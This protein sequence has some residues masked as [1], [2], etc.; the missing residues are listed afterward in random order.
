[1]SKHEIDIFK[2]GEFDLVKK[3]LDLVG[4]IVVVLDLKGNVNYINNYG[5]NLLGYSVE[6][7]IGKSWF[8]NFIPSRIRK[9]LKDIFSKIIATNGGIK[10]YHYYENPILTKNGE[11][12]VIAW[13][14]ILFESEDGRIIG[15]LSTG[16]NITEKKLIYAAKKSYEDKLSF[17]NYFAT[18]LNSAKSI[19]EIYEHVIEGL[20]KTLGYEY[21]VILAVERN[22]LRIKTYRGLKPYIWE[23]P[24]NSQKGLTIKAV[25][26][27]RTII[28]NDTWNDKDYIEGVQ[29]VRSELCVPIIVNDKVHGVIDVQSKKVN[30]FS[31]E[32]ARLL[33]ILAAHTAT[34]ISNL[35]RQKSLE[36]QYQQLATLMKF[37]IE[38]IG[39]ADVRAR[40]QKVVEA[41][42]SLGWR[43]VVLSLRDENLEI[44]SQDDMITAGLSEEEKRFLWENRSPGTVWKERLSPAYEQYKIGQFYYLPYE[45]PFVRSTFAKSVLESRLSEEETWDWHPQD[46]LYAPLTLPDGRIV[47]ILSIDDPVDGR[48]PTRYALAPLE[49]FLTYAAL[50]I[51]NAQLIKQL[52][53]AQNILKEYAADLENKVKERTKELL[54]AQE[55]LLRSQRL[56]TIGEVAASVGHDLRNPLQVILYES[57]VLENIVEKIADKVDDKTLVTLK[58]HVQKIKEQI[59][60]MNRIVLDL[61]DY[62]RQIIIKTSKVDLNN[63]IMNI[64]STNKVPENIKVIVNIPSEFTIDADAES[65][66]RVFT[67]III[68]AFQAMPEGGTLTIYAEKEENKTK[69]YFKDTGIGIPKEN[70]EKL[71][72]PLF[73]TKAK[74]TGLGLAVCKRIVEAHNGTIEVESE[75]GKGTKFIINLP[76]KS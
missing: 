49:L 8:D 32:D 5:A 3:Y 53:E 56:A 29:G 76:V 17:L 13:N 58:S 10:K 30:A 21:A 55:K 65:I 31:E 38:I 27:C 15:T 71:F 7:I 62:G 66:K 11:E 39:T 63:L 44:R 35:E 61:Q 74:G 6:Q 37:S 51:E 4:A 45:D 34:A 75:L 33:E 28:S 50:A 57:F 70:L 18:T 60:Y 24:L 43:R 52:N 12:I 41:I 46:L 14:N 20:T 42:N 16:M 40:L 54:E 9:E 72:Q 69:I 19:K 68:N 1:M 23:M 48:R 47:G 26:T 22:M 59:N 25:K 36:K 64:L 2:T 67:N 73:T